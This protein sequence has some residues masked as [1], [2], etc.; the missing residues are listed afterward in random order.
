[1]T[2]AEVSAMLSRNATLPKDEP[3]V[4]GNQGELDVDMDAL[5]LNH[6]TGDKSFSLAPSPTP[7]WQ[8]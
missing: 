3:N 2:D 4:I 6:P 8:P 7:Y 1:M 5:A